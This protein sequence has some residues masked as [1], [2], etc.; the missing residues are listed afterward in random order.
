MPPSGLTA[1]AGEAARLCG[2]TG[3]APSYHQLWQAAASNRIPT[4][5]IGR[6]RFIRDED[7]AAVARYFGLEIQE[8]KELAA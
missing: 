6:C 2:L 5:T 4:V 7:Q 1:L 8:I 3:Q